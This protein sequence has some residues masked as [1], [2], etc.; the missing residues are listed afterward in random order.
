MVA[1]PKMAKAASSR[2]L[3]NAFKGHLKETEGHIDRL[4]AICEDMS[5]SPSGNDSE[6]VA[7][8]IRQGEELI[9]EGAEPEVLDAS[10]IAAA[11]KIEHYEIEGYGT[12]RTY[13]ELLGKGE[14]AKTLQLTLKEEKAA[15][16]KLSVIADAINIKAQ[17]RKISRR[18]DWD[19][20]GV[21]I[22]E[23]V[24]GIGL[25]TAA[26]LL[27]APM[28]GRQLRQRATNA[29]QQARKRVSNTTASIK[30]GG[31]TESSQAGD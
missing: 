6:A 7:G 14:I 29:A 9:E 10:L 2:Q 20:E 12:V 4:E 28:S 26:G 16:R 24:L 30:S 19:R 11:Q 13:A 22:G 8:L 31:L 5:L 3:R 25:G 17:Q 21:D 15:D 18:A 27:L 23:F 1:L